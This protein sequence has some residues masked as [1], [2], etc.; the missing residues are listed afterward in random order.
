[1]FLAVIAILLLASLKT[2]GCVWPGSGDLFTDMQRI[3]KMEFWVFWNS[4]LLKAINV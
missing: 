4:G 2:P 1:M 3:N